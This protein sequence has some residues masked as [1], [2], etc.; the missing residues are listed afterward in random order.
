[1]FEWLASDLPPELTACDLDCRMPNCRRDKFDWCEC[2]LRVA[3]WPKHEAVEP[4]RTVQ[5]ERH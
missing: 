4:R 1:M 3:L 5:T 2:R